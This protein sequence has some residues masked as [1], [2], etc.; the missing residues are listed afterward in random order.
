MPVIKLTYLPSLFIFFLFSCGQQK[1]GKNGIL[2]VNAMKL[3]MWDMVQTD[4]FANIYVR[5]DSTLNIK[6]ETD[7]LYQ[8]VFTLHKIDSTRFFK[9]FDF[10][11]KHPSNYK[12]LMDSLYA[13]ANRERENR[14]Y[15]NKGVQKAPISAE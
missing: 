12:I 7:T 10:Y 14:F 2:S 8:K 1:P 5:K 6:K 11:K 9:S 4:E 15:I 3:V 13:Y